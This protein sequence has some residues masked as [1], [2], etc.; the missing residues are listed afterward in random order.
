MLREIVGDLLDYAGA[1]AD[2]SFANADTYIV[3][4]CCCVSTYTAGLSQAIAKKWPALNPYKSRKAIPGTRRA[5]LETRAEP[6]TAAIL[7]FAN[8]I[9]AANLVCLYG[10]YGPG[11]PG[12]YHDDEIEPYDDSAKAR[13]G[14]FKWALEDMS[15]TIEDGSTL[16]FPHGIGCGL[17]GGDWDAYK[18]ALVVFARTHPSYN[19]IVVRLKR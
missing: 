4:Q 7:R 2:G 10:Q 13:L 1:S 14:F 15:S 18:S 8:G 9:S 5:T 12:V 16:Y 6:G 3:Q 19:V 17:A 11:K